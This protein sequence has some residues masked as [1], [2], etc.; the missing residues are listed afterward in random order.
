[1][2]DTW[3]ACL[4]TVWHWFA[5]KPKCM[6]CSVHLHFLKVILLHAT[7]SLQHGI[8]VLSLNFQTLQILDKYSDIFW[9]VTIKESI[10]MVGKLKSWFSHSAFSKYGA[11]KFMRNCKTTIIQWFIGLNRTSHLFGP[12]IGNRQTF[13]QMMWIPKIIQ[14]SANMMEC[15]YVEMLHLCS[16]DVNKFVVF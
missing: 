5:H 7:S 1:M 2:A 9:H 3:A 4:L 16:C 14:Y 10:E 11:A 15:E 6:F 13:T 12:Q 8:T